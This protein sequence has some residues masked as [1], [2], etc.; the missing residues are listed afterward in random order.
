MLHSSEA[1]QQYSH[2]I[3]SLL[4]IK[5]FICINLEAA[6]R[7]MPALCCYS[8]SKQLKLNIR[9]KDLF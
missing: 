9:N 5:H 4:D 3:P 1:M 2:I 8:Y 6:A 7:N